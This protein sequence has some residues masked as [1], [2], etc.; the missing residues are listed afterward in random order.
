MIIE[1]IVIGTLMFMIIVFCLTYKYGER[2]EISGSSKLEQL[3]QLEK[4]IVSATKFFKEDII[5]KCKYCGTF[6]GKNKVKFCPY[7]GA[8]SKNDGRVGESG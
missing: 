8:D 4:N 6:L 3:E 5:H 1:L 2:S 7:C